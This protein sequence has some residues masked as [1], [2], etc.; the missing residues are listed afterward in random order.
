MTSSMMQ[1][2]WDSALAL[3]PTEDYD[4]SHRYGTWSEKLYFVVESN[5]IDS[6]AILMDKLVI[7]YAVMHPQGWLP[8]QQKWQKLAIH[9]LA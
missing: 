9:L 2:F 8:R 6:F 7:W 3:E 1:K 4:D 5:K